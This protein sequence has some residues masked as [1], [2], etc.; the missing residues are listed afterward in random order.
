MRK[1]FIKKYKGCQIDYMWGR[2]VVSDKNGLT[3]YETRYGL[4]E[5]EDWI[6]KNTTNGKLNINIQ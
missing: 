1:G 4:S 6:E 2:Y 3:I 5:V